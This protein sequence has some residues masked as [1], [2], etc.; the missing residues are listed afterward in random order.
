M[1]NIEKR[2]EDQ[3]VISNAQPEKATEN[4][5][6]RK[7]LDTKLLIA[8]GAAAALVI[9]IVLIILLSPKDKGN[10]SGGNTGDSSSAQK[11]YFPRSC[12]SLI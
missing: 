1:E 3:E 8:I 2:P 11:L 9:A 12:K 5:P 6:S 10:P 4:A 7:K